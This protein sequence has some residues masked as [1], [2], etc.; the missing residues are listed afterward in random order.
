MPGADFVLDKALLAQSVM[1][2][3]R[4]VKFGTVD[5]SCTLATVADEKILG[6]VQQPVVAADVNKQVVDVRMMGI[7]KWEAE[8]AI[9]RGNLVTVAVT[10]GRAAPISGAAGSRAHG[11]ALSS[12]AAAGDIIDVWLL[13]NGQTSAAAPGG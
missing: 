8:A 11:M 10:T 6:V 9:T 2:K 3:F 7:T 13:P 5:E 4:A 1:S 12:A